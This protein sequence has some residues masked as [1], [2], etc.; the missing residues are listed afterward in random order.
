MS[1]EGVCTKPLNED[2][3]QKKINELQAILEELEE[4]EKKVK[5][6]HVDC[7]QYGSQYGDVQKFIKDLLF[8]LTSNI[9]VIRENQTF[10]RTYLAK[11]KDEPKEI[12]PE[13][14]LEP[15]VK[16]TI[17]T[18]LI[19]PETQTMSTQTFTDQPTDNIMVIQSMN[20]E[21]ETIQIY[22]M[23]CSHEEGREVDRNV[24]VE[25]KYVRGHSGDPKRA[26]ELFLKNV[27]KH[28]E[29]TFVEPDETTT[30]II[31]DPD[32]SKRIIVRKLTK[33][34]QQIVKQEE[35]NDGALPDHIRSQLGLSGTTHDVIVGS[36]DFPF[37][38]HSGIT[39]SSLHA[40]IEH[41]SHRVIRKTR[42][43]IKKIVIIDGQE[44]I[45]E[46]VIEEPDEVEEF[47]E[48]QPA[49]E[50]DILQSQSQQP[51]TETVI[52]TSREETVADGSIQ[53]VVEVLTQIEQET[54]SVEP[55]QITE[56][57]ETSKLEMI[58]ADIPVEVQ[59]DEV[60][61]AVSE[62]E[63][64]PDQVFKIITEAPVELSASEVDKLAPIEDIKDIW[65]YD[66]PYIASQ[67]TVTE[68]VEL[69]ATTKQDSD[70]QS[71]WPQN[72][73]IGSNIDFNEY[74]FDR[75]IEISSDYLDNDSFVTVDP[76]LNAANEPSKTEVEIIEEEKPTVEKITHAT[77]EEIKETQIEAII[78]KETIDIHQS[79]DIEKESK[80]YDEPQ[81]LE[82]IEEKLS[83]EEI[84]P[85]SPPEIA[86]ITI[87]KT[88][89]FLEQERI[90]AEATMLI[91]TEPSGETK[92]DESIV[93]QADRSLG[94]I[95]IHSIEEIPK[96]SEQDHD[97]PI[98]FLQ[99]MSQP[100][101]IVLQSL[102]EQPVFVEPENESFIDEPNKSHIEMIITSEFSSF[103]E[104]STP[105]QEPSTIL[106]SQEIE[107]IKVEPLNEE[108]IETRIDDSETTEQ[109]TKPQNTML[110]ETEM[111]ISNEIENII[112][113]SPV[114]RTIEGEVSQPSEETVS[115]IFLHL[116]FLLFVIRIFI[117]F[118]AN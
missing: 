91:T 37:E 112:E 73:T 11:L 26:S 6:I 118:L 103:K 80:I 100:E 67:S 66:T 8:G 63:N 57:I 93:S 78:E 76:G 24:I 75:T 43:I 18:E 12:K 59:R 49:I 79:E 32:G 23:P 88:V 71:I 34:T 83:P 116:K 109:L 97:A 111:F 114:Q 31:V 28:F 21:G 36:P 101:E 96:T 29:T 10:I 42:K 52:I 5:E 99:D 50:Y 45:T 13:Q 107:E 115:I 30:E 106:D 33:T 19:K 58:T 44:H 105:L 90:N 108:N 48:S 4:K 60:V 38:Q 92:A 40:V 85:I 51:T 46:E 14:T 3:A 64:Q 27:P 104:E 7:E 110:V 56:I 113:Q 39:E 95:V 25:A 87:T 1:L 53:P 102:S 94:E 15:T 98:G 41:V 82:L 47:S 2:D 77:Q 65:P 35:Y 74:S 54:S 62:G 16:E 68:I 55:P 89:T 117:Q 81:N 69:P 72:L 17:L 84:R 20:D 86:T 22:N 61:S 9:Q 70:S